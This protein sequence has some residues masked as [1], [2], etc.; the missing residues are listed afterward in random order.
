M[1][2]SCP[3]VMYVLMSCN[4][5]CLCSVYIRGGGGTSCYTESDTNERG[6]HVAVCVCAGWND[7]TSG[8]SGHRHYTGVWWGVHSYHPALPGGVSL[9]HAGCC[10][11]LAIS[12]CFFIIIYL[13]IFCCWFHSLY[14]EGP[15]HYK[16]V[17]FSSSKWALSDSVLAPF[18]YFPRLRS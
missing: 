5:K 18:Q 13:L 7:H 3:T 6:L 14:L 1:F 11:Y 10:V 12:I 2:S 16:R 4:C 17:V 9:P 15:V 8:W